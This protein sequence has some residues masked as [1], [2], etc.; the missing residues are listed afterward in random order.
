M[1]TRKVIKVFFLSITFILLISSCGNKLSNEKAS[2]M[3]L[4]NAKSND[5]LNFVKLS[6]AKYD[7][8]DFRS[9]VKYNDY[10][11]TYDCSILSTLD[12]DGYIKILLPMEENK[13]AIIKFTDKS[14]EFAIKN[15][16]NLSGGK[17]IAAGKL[18]EINITGIK[19]TGDKTRTVES[20]I[21]YEKTP[22][23]KLCQ[24]GEFSRNIETK[25]ALYDDGWR[26]EK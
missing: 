10:L 9:G 23:G 1:K 13:K 20:T 17:C 21:T 18:K 24:E 22:F 25:F 4:E 15:C 14:E 5:A 2:V 19:E 16:S 7:F 8:F 11:A 6:F 12:K 26:I 3:I